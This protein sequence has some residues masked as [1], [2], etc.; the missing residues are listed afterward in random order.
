MNLQLVI[1]NN[2]NSA[3]LLDLWNCHCSC[4]SRTNDIKKLGKYQKIKP[5]DPTLN[6]DCSIC[7]DKFNV[8][9]YKRIL[10][11]G[12]SFHKKCVDKWLKT[13]TTCPICRKDVI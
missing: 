13:H 5:N 10:E 11:C 6:E 2:N 8:G 4:V 7:L 9:F 12:H 3:I 1:D